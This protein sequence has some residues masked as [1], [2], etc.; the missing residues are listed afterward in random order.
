MSEYH[1]IVVGGGWYGIAA[2]RTYLQLSPDVSILLIDEGSSLG[3]VWSK[4]R[5]Y[6]HLY[7]NQP[8]P[9]FEFPDWSMK[10]AVRVQDWEDLSGDVIAR[11][12]ELYA[13]KFGIKEKVR[14]GYRLEKADRDSTG[15]WNLHVEDVKKGTSGEVLKCT[16][17]IMALGFASLPRIPPLDTSGFS[18]QVFHM[19][20]FG[21]KHQ[22][23]VADRNIKNITVVGGAKSAW[24]AAGLFA[25]EGKNV[26]WLIRENGMGP[27]LMP[28]GRPDG[29]KHMLEGKNV[30]L[31]G[32]LAP[33]PYFYDWWL[34]RLL[35]GGGNWFGRWFANNFWKLPLKADLKKLDT[36]ARRILTPLTD[37]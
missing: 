10:D 29:K 16:K 34:T 11:Y 23:I 35:Y 32:L 18:G 30:R 20:E 27:A 13:Q 12:L 5:V 3:G 24:E 7:T 19:K 26:S 14:L 17:L 28:R 21:Q 31:M 37:R 8:S 4:E 6:P 2:V 36:A 22:D 9:L 33:N 15:L 1:V 25:L